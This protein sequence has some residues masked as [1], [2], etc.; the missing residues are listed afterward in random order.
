LG[1]FKL[2]AISN[3]LAIFNFRKFLTFGNF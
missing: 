1:N 2:W 3:F